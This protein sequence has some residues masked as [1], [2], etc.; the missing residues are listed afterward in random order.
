[1]KFGILPAAS[2]G[3]YLITAVTTD[4][5]RANEEDRCSAPASASMTLDLRE[6][7]ECIKSRLGA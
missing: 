1:M 3:L 5:R 4:P 6:T 7:L 2:V